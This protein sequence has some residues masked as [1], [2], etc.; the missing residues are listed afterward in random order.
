MAAE[1]ANLEL[2]IYI[3][4][5]FLNIS[6]RTVGDKH[7]PWVGGPNGLLPLAHHNRDVTESFGKG[8]CD[9]FRNLRCQRDS[10]HI[11]PFNSKRYRERVFHTVPELCRHGTHSEAP[12]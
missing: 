11:M 10:D 8:F 4:L 9:V 1:I 12:F 5:L 7:L 6:G 3:Y 2:Y